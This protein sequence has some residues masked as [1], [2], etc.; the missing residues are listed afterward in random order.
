MV[1]ADLIKT[2]FSKGDNEFAITYEDMGIKEGGER[3][4]SG[5]VG[6]RIGSTR[7][8]RSVVTDFGVYANEIEEGIWAGYKEQTDAPAI[9]PLN[10]W[11]QFHRSINISEVV[12]ERLNAFLVDMKD[13]TNK[14]DARDKK[15]GRGKGKGNTK[16]KR[17]RKVKPPQS[18]DPS[19]TPTAAPKDTSPTTLAPQSID[20]SP[21]AAAPSPSITE[22][23]NADDS[24]GIG[25]G[26]KKTR[27]DEGPTTE[28][29]I[30]DY[31]A[32][33]TKLKSMGAMIK[34]RTAAEETTEEGNDDVTAAN[35]STDK[36]NVNIDN[37]ESLFYIHNARAGKID[38]DANAGVV[39]H[40][41]LE[42]GLLG[43][44]TSEK[45]RQ[46]NYNAVMHGGSMSWVPTTHELK[47]KNRIGKTEKDRD[48]MQKL[49]KLFGGDI[50]SWSYEAQRIM[51]ACSL[52]GYG[53][54]DEATVMIMSGSLD[55]VRY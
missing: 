19:P 41:E 24:D 2:A 44:P 55:G 7:T 26:T 13:T 22:N 27:T 38:L 14:R 35:E 18:I 21:A 54:S 16:K 1:D 49:E 32:M 20:P 23:N 10:N 29:L 40:D 3:V 12:K 15:K 28:E 37:S 17:G 9:H 34:G 46:T 36:T 39:H 42:A 31:N 45:T 11:P 53:C 50:S 4:F 33:L 25:I 6:K 47:I 30:A 48:I 52:F 5:R 51:T 8:G 43:L